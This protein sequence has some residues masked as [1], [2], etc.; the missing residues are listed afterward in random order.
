MTH[1]Y[2]SKL[3]LTQMKVL[4]SQNIREFSGNP[5]IP[6]IVSSGE[7]TEP[8]YWTAIS[9]STAM[10]WPG[11]YLAPRVSFDAKLC[12]PPRWGQFAQRGESVPL[13]SNR[14][15]LRSNFHVAKKLRHILHRKR[16]LIER[17][18][19]NRLYEIAPRCNV[20]LHVRHISLVTASYS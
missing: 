11:V 5:R 20:S 3:F 15:S 12:L 6:Y 7:N 14:L 1:L 2:L 19:R 9:Q 17:L 13:L 18:C 10:F 16:Y 4:H 8:L